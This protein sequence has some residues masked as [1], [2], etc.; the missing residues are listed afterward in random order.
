MRANYNGDPIAL[1]NPTINQFF[2]TAA[3]SVPN[4]GTYGN[5]AR[6]IITGPNSKSLNMQFTRDVALGGNRSVS[7]NVN[8][9]NILNLVNS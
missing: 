2:N 8:A 9:T 4:P 6:N 3:F 5:S 7:V 1:D